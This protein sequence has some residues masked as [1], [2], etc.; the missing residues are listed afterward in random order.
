[1]NLSTTFLLV[2]M[3]ETTYAVRVQQLIAE[4]EKHPHKEELIALALDQLADDTYNLQQ[5]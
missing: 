1:M 3:T 4:V 5:M 2:P